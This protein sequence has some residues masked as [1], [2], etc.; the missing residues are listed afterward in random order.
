[1]AKNLIVSTPEY[2]TFPFPLN[3]S[4]AYVSL[5]CDNEVVNCTGDLCMRD[6]FINSVPVPK[7]NLL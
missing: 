5:R 3:L 7:E 6:N 2:R 4:L 1:M